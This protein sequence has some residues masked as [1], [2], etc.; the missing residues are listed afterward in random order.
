MD[1]SR[2]GSGYQLNGAKQVTKRATIRVE[3]AEEAET[4]IHTAYR[5]VNAHLQACLPKIYT[6][7]LQA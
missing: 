2:D 1:R 6:H 7:S 3:G 5:Q 4:A